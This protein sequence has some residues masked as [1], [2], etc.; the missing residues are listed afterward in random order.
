MDTRK[1]KLSPLSPEI[2]LNRW[3][4]AA[5]SKE[6]FDYLSFVGSLQWMAMSARPDIA[7]AAGLLGRYAQNPGPE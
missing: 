5:V 4:G 7:F 3:E 6:E 2:Q 1:V